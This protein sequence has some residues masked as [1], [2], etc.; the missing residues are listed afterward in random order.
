MINGINHTQISND[1]IDKYMRRVSGAATQVFLVISRK[2]IG[3]HKETDNISFSQIC[4][5]TG[6]SK[7][8]AIKAVK[9]LEDLNL[10]IVER[11][12]SNGIKNINTYSINYSSVVQNLTD[13]SAENEQGVVQNLTDG[14][15]ENEHTKETLTK[16]KYKEM[17]TRRF[18]APKYE[19][20]VKY[21]KE[22]NLT[23]D[24][25]FFFDYYNDND[26]FDRD[27]KK[28]KNWKGKALT[29]SNRNL[30][31]TGPTTTFK[32]PEINYPKL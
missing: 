30:T 31:R 27:G 17:E 21:C 9:E 18:K 19:E 11:S 24:S 4:E 7:N 1:F 6:L 28:I 13:G 15:A 10:V 16:E 8:T 22:K 5:M 3:W 20:V 29:W 14:S 12:T 26:W 23:I 32:R 25:K 2:T